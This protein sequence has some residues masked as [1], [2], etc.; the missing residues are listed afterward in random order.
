MKKEEAEAQTAIFQK[1]NDLL[2]KWENGDSEAIT[3]LN[4]MNGWFF[5]GVRKTYAR[6]GIDS[7]KDY[8]ESQEY[9]KEK[10]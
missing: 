2:I 4:L 6:L 7:E 5:D 1:A 9:K 10:I 8:Y 3:L